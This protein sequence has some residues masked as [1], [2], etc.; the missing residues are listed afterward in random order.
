MKLILSILFLFLN[1]LHALDERKLTTQEL[2]Y[3]KN[4]PTIKIATY[5]VPPYIYYESNEVK[6][7]YIDIAKEALKNSGLTPKF[8][9][10]VALKDKLDRLKNNEVDAGLGLIKTKSRE[11]YLYFTDTTFN[12]QIGIFGNKNGPIINDVNELS[13]KDIVTYKGYALTENFLKDYPNAKKIEA[14]TA[15][16][17]LKLLNLNKG[18]YAL[19]EEYSGKFIALKNNLHDIEL[20]GYLN[21]SFNTS[22]FITNKQN[23]ILASILTK[24]YNDIPLNKIESIKNKWF[25]KPSQLLTK[26]K[27]NLTEEEKDYLKNNPTITLDFT[28]SFDPL[29]IK[30]KN[31]N[32]IGVLPEVMD[33]ISKEIPSNV[34]VANRNWFDILK[35][36]KN[37]ET[38]SIAVIAKAIAINN[39]M[40]FIEYPFHF[41]TTV[42]ARKDRD[43][44]LYN[45]ENL[46]TLKIA[47]PRKIKVIHDYLRAN[48]PHRNL[49][50][51][52]DTDA[53]INSLM[54]KESDVA[55][56]FSFSI[57][58][59]KK[60]NNVFIEPIFILNELDST[61]GIAIS[62]DQPI[63]YSILTKAIE[64]IDRSELLNILEDW[65]VIFDDNKTKIIEVNT[66]KKQTQNIIIIITCILL[67][68]IIIIGLYNEKVVKRKTHI[69]KIV[70]NL[71]KLVLSI[72]IILILLLGYLL[73]SIVNKEG[74]SAEIIN[75]S[76]KQ[77]M[78]SQRSALFA[79][80]FFDRRNVNDLIT[81][82]NIIKEIEE[83]HKFIL[84]NIDKK[85][86]NDI[87]LANIN[88]NKKIY[89][90]IKLHKN[91]IDNPNK[92][93]FNKLFLFSKEILPILNTAV[94]YH[95]E[96]S[97]E[98]LKNLTIYMWLIFGTMIILGLFEALFIFNPL[99]E[100]LRLSLISIEKE[101]NKVLLSEEKA[102]KAN[103]AKSDF[104]A[105][106][107]HEIRT[108][109]NGII[110][111]NE[112]LQDTNLDEK[113]KNYLEKSKQ[114]SYALLHVINDILDYSKIEAGKLEIVHSDF[115]LNELIENI[116]SLFSY[117]IEQKG[118]N[119]DCNIDKQIPIYL[120]GDNLRI[121]QI[122]NNLVG[123][124]IKFT[125]QGSVTLEIKLLSKEQEDIKIQFNVKDTGI[126]I[127]K[128]N[129]EKLFKSFSQADSTT[130]KEYGGTGL[131]LAISKQLVELMNGEIF[132][133]SEEN[134]GSVFG[135][136]LP[137]KINKNALTRMKEKKLDN[138]K[139]ILQDTKKALLVEDVEINQIVTKKILENLGFEVDIANDGLEAVSM[140]KEKYYD[141]IFMD[142]QMPNMDG[143]EAS[144]KIREFNQL[145]PI[146]ALTAAVMQDDKIKSKSAGMNAHASKPI[147]LKEITMILDKYFELTE[148]V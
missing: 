54:A 131:G 2:D 61:T 80:E 34:E 127:S 94:S 38:N 16:E 62:K 107:S 138:K 17:M 132:F 15:I 36:V 114:S 1:L 134:I 122:L 12:L 146:I 111:L 145:T 126:G 11:E 85:S 74:I 102:I 68:L 78:L 33:L 69:S 49:I 147:E 72:T 28:T 143:F 112:L 106:M 81:Y 70:N 82:K 89:D 110:G 95:E 10:P 26:N 117:T 100:R 13:N 101:K 103:E 77:R 39:D 56:S 139:Y 32:F 79:K 35:S 6:G 115:N 5:D 128:E 9:K 83:N 19:Q 23:K 135:F 98:Q 48:F 120:I 41:A 93:D 4:N 45:L 142:L 76:G 108:P 136:N 92:N 65:T 124:A 20:K 86:K 47:Y 31:G 116:N 67:A 123:N 43:F 59:L 87:Y 71:Q 99:I 141:I 148:V 52:D 25:G 109:L 46:S 66:K 27:I 29:L 22:I 51:L 3:I 18:Q 130:T 91:F 8:Q 96:T 40:N 133:K 118:L 121:I 7:Y 55:V 144:E 24:G 63:L 57:Y 119:F 14:N 90:Y 53:V 60:N 37:K 58:S 137:L 75:I 125:P 105:N 50:P 97:K 64:K 113:Q 129:Q 30:D 140:T 88:V 44:N 84:N 21:K 73:N 104:L 42:F